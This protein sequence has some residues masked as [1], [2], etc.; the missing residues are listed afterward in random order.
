MSEKLQIVEDISDDNVLAFRTKASVAIDF[1]DKVIKFT[2]LNYSCEEVL[3]IAKKI[4][5]MKE[6]RLL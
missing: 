4:E 5:Q 2:D 3:S 6:S 1:K